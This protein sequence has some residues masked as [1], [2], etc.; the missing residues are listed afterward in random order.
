MLTKHISGSIKDTN[1][2]AKELAKEILISTKNNKKATVVGL[3]GDLGAGKTTFTKSFAKAL[4]VKETIKS[5]T[6]NLMKKYEIRSTKSET[7]P[8]SKILNPKFLYHIDAYRIKKPKEM[9]ML[10]WK[11]MINDPRNIIV[12]EWA[13]NIKKVFPGQH[14]GLNLSHL[15]ESRRG[16]DIRIVK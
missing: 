7:N 11:K 9:L 3:S 13:E 14:F 6:F 1:K 4:G 5:P 12:V 15:G 16:I 2:I 10:E 8:K